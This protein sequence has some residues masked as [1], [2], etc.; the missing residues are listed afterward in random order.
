[1]RRIRKMFV[2]STFRG[3]AGLPNFGM[4]QYL[5]RHKFVLIS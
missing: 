3:V 1:M 4:G 2:C 5:Y